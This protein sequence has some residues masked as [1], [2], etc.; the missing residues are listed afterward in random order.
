VQKEES[1]ETTKETN[2]SKSQTNENSKLPVVNNLKK[3]GPKKMA[4]KREGKKLGGL[5]AS[6]NKL[7]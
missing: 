2:E 3:L 7:K 6:L 5:A 4:I 1:D